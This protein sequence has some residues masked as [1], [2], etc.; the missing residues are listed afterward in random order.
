MAE[1][2]SE[3]EAEGLVSPILVG[4]EAAQEFD[5]PTCKHMTS[6]GS[7]VEC[8]YVAVVDG[9]HLM[10]FPAAAWHQ[11]LPSEFCNPTPCGNLRQWSWRVVP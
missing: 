8:I 1:L 6:S 9:K 7:M 4:G 3:E 5:Y 10:V 2:P 11:K